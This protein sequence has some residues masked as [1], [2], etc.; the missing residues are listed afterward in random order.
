[1]S[2]GIFDDQNLLLEHPQDHLLLVDGTTALNIFPSTA[3]RD[4]RQFP[5]DGLRFWPVPIDLQRDWP[6][7]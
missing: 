1:M 2:F 7:I 3:V 5:D 6:D 4:Q